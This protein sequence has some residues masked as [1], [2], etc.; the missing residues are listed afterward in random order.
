MP[1]V[2]AVMAHPDDI[3]IT[4][5]GTL[6]LLRQAGWRP[7]LAT[8]TA[9]DLGSSTL[10][11]QEIGA[12]R[13]QEAAASAAILDAPYTCLGFEDLK[14]VFGE[15]ATRRLAGF[16]RQVRPDLVIV[17]SPLDYMADHQ[18]TARIVR[19]AAFASTMPGVRESQGGLSLPPCVGIPTVLYADPIDLVDHFGHRV[20]APFMVDVTDVIATKEQMLASHASQRTWLQE[21]HGED[22]YLA[23][24]YRQS[25]DRARDFG[26]PSVRYAEGFTQ[27][28][29][30][31]F[32]RL[33]VLTAALGTDRVRAHA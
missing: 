15:A 8:M 11:P 21:Q 29:G 10:G 24:M 23:W 6:T 7:H 5:A 12:L 16:L 2:L 3:E 32:P 30:H 18:E 28:L 27:H 22:D 17:P 13:R 20:P 26:R 25:A 9:G 31:A 19:E 14:I 4:C 33:D 1:T